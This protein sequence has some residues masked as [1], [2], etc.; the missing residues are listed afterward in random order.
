VIE[1]L[2]QGTNW[3][4]NEGDRLLISDMNTRH[5][6][7]V[8]GWIWRNR[9]SLKMSAESSMAFGPKPTAEAASDAFDMAFEELLN[10]SANSW[11]R[12]LP[13]CKAM[14]DELEK[15]GE[16]QDFWFPEEDHEPDD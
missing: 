11:V 9:E 5:L 3:V 12:G 15:R 7:N 2:Y 4:T 16:R 13:V 10:E 8:L 14:A 6:K 1:T